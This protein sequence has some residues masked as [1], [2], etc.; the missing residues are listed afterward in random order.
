MGT[1]KAFAQSKQNQAKQFDAGL[2]VSGKIYR[3]IDFKNL[4]DSKAIDILANQGIDLHEYLGDKRY[5]VSIKSQ[6]SESL[7]NPLFNSVSKLE[8][9]NK[10]SEDIWTNR[11]CGIEDRLEQKL[12]IQHMPGL[13]DQNS[14]NFPTSLEFKFFSIQHLTEYFMHSCLKAGSS[15][16]QKK[17]G[18]FI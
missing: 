8:L 17:L 7:Q 5:L 6:E 1:T 18:Y 4:P 10:V 11:P 13:N 9:P 12:M 2:A 15:S 14:M 16:W 3:V